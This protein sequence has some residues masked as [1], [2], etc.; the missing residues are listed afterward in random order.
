MKIG[1]FREFKLS[2]N[3]SDGPRLIEWAAVELSKALRAVVQALGALT[4][5]DNFK[6]FTDEQTIAAGAEVAIRN[7]LI[8]GKIPTGRI[9]LKSTSPD[10]A[11]G[12]TAW[13]SDFVYLKNYGVTDAAVKVVFFE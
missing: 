9:I 12:P 5:D 4:F 7:R 8:S 11:D 6:S 1:I 2:R 3:E 10:V 13:S